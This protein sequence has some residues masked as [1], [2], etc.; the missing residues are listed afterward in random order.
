MSTKDTNP[1]DA[2]GIRKVAF[3]CIPWGVIAE[4]GLAML[5]G[6]RKYGRHNYR[7]AGV[8]ASVYFDGN[9]RH[10]TDWYEG[11]DIDPDSGENHVTKAIACLVVLR[12]SM[13]TGNW[14]D[15]RPPRKLP[16]G[17]VADMNKRAAHII[18]KYPNAVEPCT[19][20]EKLHVGGGGNDSPHQFDDVMGD[21]MEA[22]VAREKD[23]VST[24]VP[25]QPSAGARYIVPGGFDLET[26]VKISS[27]DKTGVEILLLM[28]WDEFFNAHVNPDKW[29]IDFKTKGDE[30][31]N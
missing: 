19:E 24:I 1:K 29:P 14:V 8:R 31:C 15:D 21:V 30:K 20:T 22:R 13:M 7:I 12:D 27:Y 11:E 3:S 9:M 17:W 5:E 10:M 16:K 26:T 28:S 23:G 6:A 4:L 25:Y 2:V 18:D